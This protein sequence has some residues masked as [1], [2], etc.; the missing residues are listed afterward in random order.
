[1][2]LHRGAF[3]S[4]TLFSCRHSPSL[5]R[6]SSYIASQDLLFFFFIDFGKT[7]KLLELNSPIVK[8]SVLDEGSTAVCFD[9]ETMETI[10]CQSPKSSTLHHMKDQVAAWEQAK[11]ECK[12]QEAGGVVGGKHAWLHTDSAR[13]P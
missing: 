12:R 10:N 9:K 5:N 4:K 11:G 13:A 1:M 6:I 8:V 7:C 3:R 2:Y